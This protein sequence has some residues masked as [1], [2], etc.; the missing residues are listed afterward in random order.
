MRAI[1]YFYLTLLLEKVATLAVYLDYDSGIFHGLKSFPNHTS[2]RYNAAVFSATFA[3]PPSRSHP[4]SLVTS[5][6]LICVSAKT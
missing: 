1:F 6:F 3:Q 4:F 2:S 5:E